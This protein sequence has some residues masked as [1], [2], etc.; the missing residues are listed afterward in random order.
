VM[1]GAMPPKLF[2]QPSTAVSRDLQWVAAGAMLP[3][4][5]SVKVIGQTASAD[6]AKQLYQIVTYGLAAMSGVP[7]TISPDTAKL[8]TPTLTNDQLV[9]TADKAKLIAVVKEMIPS[10]RRAREAA[11]RV[12]SMS[13]MRQILMGC[14][15][16][17]NDNNGKWPDDLK[18]IAK[19]VPNPVVMK[20]PHHPD[21]NPAFIYLKPK[22][23][24]GGNP[25]QMMVLYESHKNFGDGINIGF[26]DGHVEYVQSKQR[27]DEL[28]AAT[29]L[30]GPAR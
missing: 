15:M 5:V 29:E 6:A 21:L 20:N 19:Y 8:I 1:G 30:E 26:A 14:V 7:P 27:F 18:G 10:L 2:D 11:N 23:I 25:G 22:N 9:L 12:A 16:Y 28:L 17:A 4:T 24:R 13:N 3:P